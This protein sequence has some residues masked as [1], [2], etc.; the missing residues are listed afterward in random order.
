MHIDENPE[1]ARQFGA[2]PGDF[3][4]NPWP[5]PTENSDPEDEVITREVTEE[6]LINNPEL[7]ESEVKLSGM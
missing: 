6:D 3:T 5:K 7:A 4:Y 1:A 2:V